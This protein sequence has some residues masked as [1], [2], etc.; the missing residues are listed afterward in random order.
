MKG[1][2]HAI[3]SDGPVCVYGIH[4]MKMS[5][6]TI[7]MPATG[8]PALTDIDELLT[9]AYQNFRLNVTLQGIDPQFQQLM[10]KITEL[11][12]RLAALVKPRIERP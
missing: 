10:D 4:I 11:E 9:R 5:D 3:E 12:K 2:E 8:E 7:Q 1:D 6:G